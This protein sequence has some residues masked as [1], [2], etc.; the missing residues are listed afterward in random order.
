[1]DRRVPVEVAASWPSGLVARYRGQVGSGEGNDPTGVT[2]RDFVEQ[3]IS[4]E[5]RFVP[6]GGLADRI[7][8]PLRLSLLV[9]YGTNREC[10]VATG[11]STCV[12][13]IDQENRAASLTLDGVFSGAEVGVQLSLVDRRSFTDLRSGLT[14]FQLGVWGRLLFEAGPVERLQG[15]ADPF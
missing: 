11:Q 12:D 5:T 9:E 7:E 13:F 15:A 4:L 14:Q 1:V 10:R 2:D 6:G 3:G 8:E